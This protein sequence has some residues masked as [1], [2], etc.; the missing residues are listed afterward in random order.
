MTASVRFLP[1]GVGR[2]GSCSV[3]VC[4]LGG[5]LFVVVFRTACNTFHSF[6]A[7]EPNS[8]R[9]LAFGVCGVRRMAGLEIMLATSFSFFRF[10][11]IF[12][13]WLLVCGPW[14]LVCLVEASGCWGASARGTDIVVDAIF[15]YL[16]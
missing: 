12:F 7:P 13:F 2:I 4:V 16:A 11:Y 15:S 5:Y 10:L 8:T 14:S 9:W 1:T 6:S 3:W